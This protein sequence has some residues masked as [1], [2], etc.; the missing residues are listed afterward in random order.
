MNVIRL[1]MD[2]G[3]NL[4]RYANP[5]GNGL[6][7]VVESFVKDSVARATLGRW[8]PCPNASVALKISRLV[9]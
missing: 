4:Y 3:D 9:C 2:W 7:S 6:P 8:L 1:S 5:Y